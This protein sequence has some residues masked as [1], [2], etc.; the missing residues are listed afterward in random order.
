[1]IVS[2]ANISARRVKLREILLASPVIDECWKIAIGYS[3]KAADNLQSLP[4]S[5]SKVIL[6]SM[7][8]GAVR[9]AF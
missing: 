1:L 6:A 8:E 4:D 3:A 7:A 5:T 9:R 2:D